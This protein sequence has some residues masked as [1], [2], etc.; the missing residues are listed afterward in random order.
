MDGGE[1][2][3]A[4]WVV[5][6][7]TSEIMR[8][9]EYPPQEPPSDNGRIYGDKVMQ[10]GAGLEGIE[11]RYGEDAYQSL[12][13][14]RA[15]AGNGTLLAV[16]HGGGWTNGYKEWMAFMAPALTA[17]GVSFAT[18]GYRLAPAHLFPAGIDDAIAALAWLHANAATFDYDPARI[19]LGGHSAGGHY[20]AL[21]A[22]RRGW[23]AGAGLPGDVVR[24]CLPI[25]GVYDFGAQ[26]GLSARPRFL[27]AVGNEKLASPID[28][29]EGK[30]PPF[31]IAHGD[32]DF[33]HLI[34]QAERMEA[35]LRATGGDVERVVLK[36][37]NHFTASYAGGEAAGPWVPRALDWMERTSK[38]R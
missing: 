14:F 16:M 37:R 4:L 8:L 25:S 1:R 18:I 13:I 9:E 21:L 12:A 27:G 17:A 3:P 33:P 28:R 26:S 30:P 34:K 31:L 20:A 15:P 6:C 29:I 23:Q 5:P 22:V 2:G 24:G 32:E 10:L 38:T 35:V 7:D 11:R 36:G 19:F